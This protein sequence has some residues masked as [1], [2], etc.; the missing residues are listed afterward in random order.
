L[1]VFM[2]DVRLAHS[3]ILCGLAIR[4]HVYI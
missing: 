1:G 3:I 4:T 2:E